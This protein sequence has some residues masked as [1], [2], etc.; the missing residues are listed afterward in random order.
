MKEVLL[1]Y[2]DIRV[3]RENDLLSIANSAL[4][5]RLDL[6]LNAPR[7][8]SLKN[9]AG[10]EFASPDKLRADLSF[11]GLNQPHNPQT[12]WTLPKLVAEPPAAGDGVRVRL[13]MFEPISES[14]YI[15]DYV[16]YPDLPVIAI[17]NAIQTRV[18]PNLCWTR[19]GKYARWQQESSCRAMAESCADG[20]RLAPE[21][22]SHHA[23]EF[24]ANTDGNRTLVA[25]H[26]AT[27]ATHLNGNLLFCVTDEGAGFAY[28][29]EAPPSSERRDYEAYDFR[30]EGRELFSCNWGIH[31]AEM[32]PDQCYHGYRHVLL[33]FNHPAE[34]ERILKRYLRLRFPD[35]PGHAPAVTVN[36][37]GCGNYPQ[38]F[39]LAFTKAEIAAAAEIGAD[40]YQIDDGWQA[41]Q[42]LAE[43]SRRNRHV[44]PEFWD[45]A[46][47]IGGEAGMAD[48]AR[49][50]RDHGIQLGLWFAPS[51]PIEYRDWEWMGKYLVEL[52]RR[53]HIA[54]YKIDAMKLRTYEAEANIR[55]LFSLAQRESDGKIRF[56][57]DIT[58]GQRGGYFM[59]QEYGRIFLE[60]RFMNH[61][62]TLAYSPEI[63]LNN[64]WNLARYLNIQTLQIEIPNPEDFDPVRYEPS[65][66]DP[67]EYAIEYWAA[68]ALFANPL[69]WYT[70]STMSA[71]L[72][73][74]L[75]MMMDWHHQL[76]PALLRGTVFPVGAEPDGKSLTGFRLEDETETSTHLLLFRERHCETTT[77]AD[78]SVDWQLLAGNG[79]ISES[80]FILEQRASFALFAHR[81]L[82]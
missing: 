10:Y 34:A 37:W 77:F 16:I 64:L 26:P 70:P 74:R 62:G 2:R 22:N 15:R 72:R 80:G 71:A 63:I 5:R 59:L 81:K 13:N 39:S 73:R 3:E 7:T 75:R 82:K 41:G 4:V 6:S 18:K 24:F 19:R 47:S 9:A 8:V 25:H 11:I 76:R 51:F 40:Q 60:N 38:R 44:K 58:N 31:P 48:L 12:P 23:V 17:E 20:L 54:D 46:D 79:K 78:N 29:Q 69:L 35:T 30:L 57:L 66:P 49:S 14:C 56:D 36:P 43:L 1:E 32:R 42:T 28:L 65:L 67:R 53:Y 68:I 21:V 55:R 27:E 61:S 33:L 50:A 45:I 52:F